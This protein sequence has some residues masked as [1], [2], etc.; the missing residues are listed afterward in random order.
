LQYKK[1]AVARKY[2]VAAKEIYETCGEE[3]EMFVYQA[4][5]WID[6]ADKKF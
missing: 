6:E 2:F 5:G 3:M 1:K 4:E